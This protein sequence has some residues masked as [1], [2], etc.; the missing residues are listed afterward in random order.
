[1]ALFSD[2]DAA[3]YQTRSSKNMT[4]KARGDMSKLLPLTSFFLGAALT[5]AVIFLNATMDVN[6]RPSALASWG[7]GAQP[8]PKPKV[9]YPLLVPIV[10]VLVI[11]VTVSILLEYCI[12]LLYPHS[13]S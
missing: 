9:S 7:N 12:F 2:D 1:M 5:A 4:C 6:W 11:I 10:S 3:H 13:L 8:V